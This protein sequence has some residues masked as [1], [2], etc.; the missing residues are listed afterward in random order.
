MPR[1]MFGDVV[2]PS[3]KVG[4]QKWYTVPLQS[5]HTWPAADRHH[6]AAPLVAADAAVD[7][8]LR[9]APPP[10]PPPP[11]PAAAGRRAA[12]ETPPRRQPEHRTD[13]G[14]RRKSR[15]KPRRHRLR[16]L[17]GG[18]E[19]G[20]PTAWPAASSADCPWRRASAAPARPVRVGGNIKAPMK[21]CNVAPV[22]RRLRSPRA[23]RASSSSR[24]RSARAARSRRPGFVDPAAR[25]GGA[26]RRETMGVH[27]DPAQRR[28]GAGHHDRHR[29][30]HVAVDRIRLT[31]FR[32]FLGGQS[33]G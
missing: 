29:P 23:S 21:T 22:I 8:G 19:G 27:A 4:G 17:V 33:N 16:R 1:D 10:P 6:P 5:V 9:A 25:P 13:R 32:I 28:A 15:Q 30:V 11:P 20:V 18:V 24:R 31:H 7:D 2:D 12:P 26:R 14:A 3:I